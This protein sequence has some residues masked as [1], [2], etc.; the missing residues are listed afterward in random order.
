MFLQVFARNTEAPMRIRALYSFPA[1]R[2]GG[3]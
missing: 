1:D 3:T 2:F